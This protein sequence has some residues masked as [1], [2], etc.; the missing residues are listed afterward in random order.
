MNTLA[1]EAEL[2]I[3]GLV[4]QTLQIDIWILADQFNI[5]CIQGA[6]GFITIKRQHFKIVAHCGYYQRERVSISR[7]KHTLIL[8]LFMNPIL[9]RQLK[10]A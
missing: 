6:D 5:N 2:Q 1:I 9:S 7:G 10:Q 3:G 4:E 8:L